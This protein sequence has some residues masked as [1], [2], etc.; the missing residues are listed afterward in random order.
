[1]FKAMIFLTRSSNLSRDEFADWWLNRH[2][3]LAATLPGLTR[4]TFNLLD[5]GSPYDA[6]VEQW[7]TSADARANCYETPE[8][9]RVRAD[10][11]ENVSARVRVLVS[12]HA[13]EAAAQSAS[14]Q[15]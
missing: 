2:R 9:A 10:S 1:M 14:P 12:E 15:G 11:L 5:P 7:F 3:P 13:F 6:V 4:H 8:G